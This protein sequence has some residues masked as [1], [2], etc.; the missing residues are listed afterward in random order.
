MDDIRGNCSSSLNVSSISGDEY[1]CYSPRGTPSQHARCPVDHIS[2]EDGES[3]IDGIQAAQAS[4]RPVQSNFRG[5]R[6]TS[7]FILED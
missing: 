5:L 2:E 4:S 6:C 3:V 7:T 1:V